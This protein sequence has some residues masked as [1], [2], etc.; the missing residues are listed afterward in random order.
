MLVSG[1]AQGKLEKFYNSTNS[2]LVQNL[3]QNIWL[4]I[5]SVSSSPSEV[6]SILVFVY[7]KKKIIQPLNRQV[8]REIF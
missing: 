8:L 6:F 4:F 2:N 7:E 3:S 1:P 5:A